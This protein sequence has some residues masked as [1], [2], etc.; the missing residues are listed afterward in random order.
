MRGA[1]EEACQR[2]MLGEITAGLLQQM[3]VTALLSRQISA[4]QAEDDDMTFIATCIQLGDA[5]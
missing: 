4:E 2:Y 3:L 1:I 5:E